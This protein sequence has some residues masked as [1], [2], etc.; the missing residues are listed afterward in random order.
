M[1]NASRIAIIAALCGALAACGPAAPAPSPSASAPT[2]TPEPSPSHT[3][4][5]IVPLEPTGQLRD[6]ATGLTSPWSVVRLDNDSALISERD[7][8]RI[9]ELTPAGDTRVAGTIKGVRHGGEG[10]LLGIEVVDDGAQRI[11]FAYHTASNDNRVIRMP[12]LGQPGSLSLGAS[13][14]VLTG[15]PRSGNHNGGRIKLGPDG[16]LYVTTGDASNPALSQ[17]ARSLAGKILRLALDGAVPDDNPTPGSFVYSMGHRNPQGI[18]WDSTGQL[19]AAEFGQNTW[20]E[21]NRIH[22]GANYGWPNVE[23]TGG[24]GDYRDP[25]AVWSTADASPSGLAIAG[26]TLFLA[27]LRGQRLWGVYNAAGEAT[28]SV[29]SASYFRGDLGRVRDVIAVGD[30]LW[31]LTN[32]TDGRGNPRSGDDR[33]IEVELRERQ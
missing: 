10:G 2:A 12:L 8:A 4:Q 18:A 14:K 16:N 33:L 1:C 27:A 20:D 29:D 23:G 31:I 25:V 9:I 30:T 26:D 24:G 21:L 15:I 7:T 22:P 32:N 6:I 17:D 19:W 13:E 5:P 3:A 28:G 11:L